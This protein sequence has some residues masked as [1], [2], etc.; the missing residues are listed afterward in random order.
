VSR[1]ISPFAK[2]AICYGYSLRWEEIGMA[3]RWIYDTEGKPAYYQEGQRIYA[4][5]TATCEFCENGGWW[6]QME[7]GAAAY[8]VKDDQVFTPDGRP[9]F[10]YA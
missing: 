8:Y 7:R 9:A 2:V 10:H 6:Y 1:L 4:L 5:Q 3:I